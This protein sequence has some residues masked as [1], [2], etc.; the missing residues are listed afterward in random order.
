MRQ[1]WKERSHC[2]VRFVPTLPFVASFDVTCD[3][4]FCVN[5]VPSRQQRQSAVIF[6]L[7]PG[8]TLFCSD[9]ISNVLL[10]GFQRH[11]TLAQPTQQGKRPHRRLRTDRRAPVLQGGRTRSV[12]ARPKPSETHMRT[13]Q[14]FFSGMHFCTVTMHEAQSGML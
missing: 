5:I 1:N 12:N 6:A 11:G 13:K 4:Y 3:K 2:A 7:H 10:A 8:G 14:K 9:L